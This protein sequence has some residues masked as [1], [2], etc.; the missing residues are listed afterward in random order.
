MD[1][2]CK[3]L[4][5]AMFGMA[6]HPRVLSDINVCDVKKRF[7]SPRILVASCG[8]RKKQSLSFHC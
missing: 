5:T 3:Q 7:L 1:V 8:S 4:W 2:M 6:K